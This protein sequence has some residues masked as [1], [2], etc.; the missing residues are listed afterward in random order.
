[1][2]NV[3]RFVIETQLQRFVPVN[4]FG[5]DLGNNTW[6]QQLLYKEY[7]SRF[8]ENTSHADFLPINQ[9]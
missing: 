2:W 9:T 1:L 5:S 3:S 6:D 4:T 7:S 8:I